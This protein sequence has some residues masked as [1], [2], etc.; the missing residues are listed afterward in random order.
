[1]CQ[2]SAI[3]ALEQEARLS[4]GVMMFSVEPVSSV[5]TTYGKHVSSYAGRIETCECVGKVCVIHFFAPLLLIP[6]LW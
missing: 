4:M 3:S 2:A 1:M 6:T 5:K